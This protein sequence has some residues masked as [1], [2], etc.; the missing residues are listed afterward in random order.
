MLGFR[1]PDIAHC[2]PFQ[3]MIQH[4]DP[5]RILVQVTNYRTQFWATRVVISEG[6]LRLDDH[7]CTALDFIWSNDEVPWPEVVVLFHLE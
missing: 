2:L 1:H 5:A 4:V 6:W 7:S 3:C